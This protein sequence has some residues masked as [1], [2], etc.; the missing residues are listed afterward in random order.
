MT[1]SLSGRLLLWYSA[2]LA[3][4]MAVF[5]G[6]VCYLAWRDRLND[7]DALLR[8]RAVTLAAALRPAPAGAFDLTL[9]PDRPEDLESGTYHVIW[10]DA[11]ALVDR[12]DP[13]LDVPMPPGPGVRTRAGRRELTT[14]ARPGA[15]VLAGVPLD[16]VR[17]EIVRLAGIMS[18]VGIAA[19]A[20]SLAG[21][22]WLIARALR[23]VHRINQTARA[24]MDGDFAAR[25]PVERVETE[26]EQLGRALNGAFERLHDSLERQRRFTAD[27][28]HELRTPLAT[29]STE[30][31]WALG[32]ERPADAYRGSL[33]VCA[34]AARRMQGIVERLLALARAEADG[35]H[36]RVLPTRIDEL[37]EAVTRELTPLAAARR[38]DVSVSAPPIVCMGDPERLH[39]AVTNV[40]M[41][42]IQYNVEGGRV[43]V[44]VR[45]AGGQAEI[46]VADSG[47]GI[48]PEHLPHVFEPFFRADPAR[49]RDAGG[50]G[51]GLAVARAAIRQH[52]GDIDCRSE[53]GR[54]TTCV[55]RLASVSQ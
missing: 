43:R 11:G 42:A 17:A 23:P 46:V 9:T 27:A 48:A 28:S 32:R 3:A 24:M 29:I 14:V 2:M 10:T 35:S 30:T 51:L 33:E 25:I 39:D 7:V 4:V 26:L 12:S 8:T 44:E 21:G 55:I 20:L 41:N 22:R 45:E 36:Q 19:L 37:V 38:L 49:S 53:P 34:R 16:D 13:A 18:A 52:G 54:G 50:S 15:L 47:V 31:Q 1:A 6:M 40:V 5:G